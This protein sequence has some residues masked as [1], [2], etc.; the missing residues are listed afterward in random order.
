VDGLGDASPD[1]ERD[2]DLV[3]D[4]PESAMAGT[5]LGESVAKIDENK[6]EETRLL[7]QK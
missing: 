5:K 2:V 6:I 4:P 3:E 7:A 1:V